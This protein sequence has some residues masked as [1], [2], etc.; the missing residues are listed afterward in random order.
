MKDHGFVTMLAEEDCNAWISTNEAAYRNLD[1][2]PMP[3]VD[4]MLRNFYC[5][6]KEREKYLV[7]SDKRR[8]I[9]GQDAAWHSLR[10]LQEFVT[11][12]NDMPRFSLMHF[13]EG[14]E[15][16]GGVISTL[17]PVSNLMRT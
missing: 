16:S 14:H 4:H 12:Y 6:A 8:C 11:N 5:V 2:I 10:Y 17:D 1:T 13:L 7:H 15:S 9:S 3:N